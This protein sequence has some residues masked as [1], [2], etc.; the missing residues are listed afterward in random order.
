[1]T[2]RKV[3]IGLLKKG[4]LMRSFKKNNIHI[5]ILDRGEEIVGSVINFCNEYGIKAAFVNGI[6]AISNITLGYFNVQDME[7][8]KKKFDNSYELVSLNGNI[9]V[10]ED[11]LIFHPHVALG[12]GDYNLIGGHLFEGTVSVTA[13]I[14]ILPLDGRLIRERDKD[15]S[16]NLITKSE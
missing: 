2:T 13:E 12:G 4:G 11:K 6:G 14:F 16:L 15:T 9:G 8:K 1:L 5:L 10:T 7:Y 3:G